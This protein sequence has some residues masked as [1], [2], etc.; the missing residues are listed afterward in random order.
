MFSSSGGATYSCNLEASFHG[1]FYHCPTGGLDFILQWLAP[2]RLPTALNFQHSHPFSTPPSCS[3]IIS[4]YR[5]V[6]SIYSNCGDVIY[7]Y[8]FHPLQPGVLSF[9][10]LI[11]IYLYIVNTQPEIGSWPEINFYSINNIGYVMVCPSILHVPPK[12]CLHLW[13]FDPSP[14]CLD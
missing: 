1:G 4:F 5:I 8:F 7:S 9:L 12:P 6:V 10:S 2:H 14:T 3:G 11:F 13:R